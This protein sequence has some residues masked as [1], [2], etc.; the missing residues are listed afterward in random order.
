[1]VLLGSDELTDLVLDN[2]LLKEPLPSREELARALQAR[3][4]Y[5]LSYYDAFLRRRGEKKI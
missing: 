1:M 5:V 2:E 4:N 3:A